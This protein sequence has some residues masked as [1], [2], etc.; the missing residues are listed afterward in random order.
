MRSTMRI[1]GEISAVVMERKTV[2]DAALS[3]LLNEKFVIIKLLDSWNDIMRDVLGCD[4]DLVT[5]TF[6][7]K[8]DGKTYAVI[9]KE[10]VSPLKFKIAQQL[11]PYPII[12][13]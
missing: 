10:K 2:D 9:P 13:E 6:S 4:F 8:V 12:R 3:K 11:S 7:T 5:Y 1:P